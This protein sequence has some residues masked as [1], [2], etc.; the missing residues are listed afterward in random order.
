PALAAV[1]TGR[2][3]LVAL[4][5]AAGAT[6]ALLTAAVPARHGVATGLVGVGAAAALFLVIDVLAARSG[7]AARAGRPGR[8]AGRPRGGDWAVDPP[9][10]GS[11]VLVLCKAET[12]D[13]PRRCGSV[14]SSSSARQSKGAAR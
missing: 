8:P 1:A 11:R 4:L 2:L 9:L 3:L 14:L 13:R 7:S 12:T 5:A 10:V 6:L